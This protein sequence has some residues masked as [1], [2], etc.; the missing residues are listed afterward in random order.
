MNFGLL[1]LWKQTWLT[2]RNRLNTSDLKERHV[3]ILLSNKEQRIQSLKVAL[4]Y[5]IVNKY[6]ITNMILINENAI[7]S[8]VDYRVLH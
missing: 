4:A 5:R 1:S 2:K 8:D 6:T 7:F 3:F